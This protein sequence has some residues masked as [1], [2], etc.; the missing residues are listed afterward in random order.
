MKQ[1]GR[2]IWVE[3]CC[4]RGNILSRESTLFSASRKSRVLEWLFY[5]DRGHISRC[6]S[7]HPPKHFAHGKCQ[8]VLGTEIN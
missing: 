8:V 3:V 7:Q 2:I 5:E 1:G 4:R 6:I